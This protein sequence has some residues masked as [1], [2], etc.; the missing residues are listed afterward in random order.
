MEGIQLDPDNQEFRMAL[1]YA[2][3]TN[4]SIYLTPYMSPFLSDDE[5]YPQIITKLN[6]V[7]I[8]PMNF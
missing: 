8:I 6:Q 1:E 7:F 4:T 3:Y 2:L 5:P